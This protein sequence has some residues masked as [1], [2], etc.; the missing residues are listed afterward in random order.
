MTELI[1]NRSL[2]PWLTAEIS[3]FVGRTDF[4]LPKMKN[5][6]K[7]W[8]IFRAH[9]PFRRSKLRVEN[10]S[11]VSAFAE[12]PSRT[13]AIANFQAALDNDFRLNYLGITWS[14]HRPDLKSHSSRFY[15]RNYEFWQFFRI[16]CPQLPDA[17]KTFSIF[18]DASTFERLE[19]SS[20]PECSSFLNPASEGCRSGMPRL[21]WIQLLFNHLNGTISE[22]DRQEGNPWSLKLLLLSG[23]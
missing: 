15:R 4:R 9:P 13:A 16:L 6:I 18:R 2:R 1:R 14:V 12:R 10:S 19:L 17:T 20:L 11:R 21:A 7:S 3:S 22:G 23:T 5:V 8:L